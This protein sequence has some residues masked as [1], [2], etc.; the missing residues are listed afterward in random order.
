MR[1]IVNVTSQRAEKAAGWGAKEVRI[2]NKA[3][4]SLID[5]LKS[6]PLKNGSNMFELISENKRLRNDWA[7]FVD[8]V[9]IEGGSGIEK[10]I[11]DNVQ[12]HVWDNP[13]INM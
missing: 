9:F 11:K 1:A 6:T 4:A 8:G 7:L 5:V 12:I 3:E 13:S 2:N 10:N